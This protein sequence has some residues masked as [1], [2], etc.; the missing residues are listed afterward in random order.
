MPSIYEHEISSYRKELD[1][2]K[3]PTLGDGNL[4][5]AT[6]AY[7]N[8][9]NLLL[10]GLCSLVEARLFEFAEGLKSNIKIDDFRGQ[11]IS[12]VERY[13]KAHDALN[14]G[15]IASW[16]KFKKLYE[17]RNSLIHSYGGLTLDD[18]TAT[19]KK[20]IDTLGFS[21][22]LV[23]DRRIRLQKQHI[24]IAINEIEKILVYMDKNAPNRVAGGI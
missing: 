13:L 6:L 16:G 5:H 14:F 19:V 8:R 17:L 11:G 2:L 9:L 21:G 15:M 12:R 10:I 24:E 4:T 18:Q 20:A 23:G 22:V 3:V 1:T 7:S